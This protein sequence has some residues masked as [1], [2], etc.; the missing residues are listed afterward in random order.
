MNIFH[1]AFPQSK[2]ITHAFAPFS[3]RALVTHEDRKVNHSVKDPSCVEYGSVGA[4][5]QI[6]NWDMASSCKMKLGV[7]PSLGCKNDVNI[8]SLTCKLTAVAQ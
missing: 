4:Q 2:A 3:V 8:L 6:L 1:D 5:Q 7:E